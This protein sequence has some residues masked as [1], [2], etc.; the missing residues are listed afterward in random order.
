M[1]KEDKAAEKKKKE[2][3]KAAKAAEK[4]AAKNKTVREAKKQ[5]DKALMNIAG[6]LPH[7]QGKTFLT[8]NF[9]ID[10]LEEQKSAINLALRGEY[11]KLKEMKI[12][13]GA[14]KD[15]RKVRKMAPEDAKALMAT[16]ALYS[17][18][19]GMALSPDQK[20]MIEDINEKREAARVALADAHG[21]DTGKEVGS[22]TTPAPSLIGH[23]SFKEKTDAKEPGTDGS[24]DGEEVDQE[25][26]PAYL[27]KAEIPAKN[28]TL[29]TA[30]SGTIGGVASAA[31]H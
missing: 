2:S 23:N 26:T 12:E 9:A 31:K 30:E 14:L 17:D 10:K 8:V 25:P 11:A 15:V 27:K 1:T 24:G 28:I 6:N 4:K 16:R 20:K 22:Q 5:S 21:G 19:F 7:G 18:M 3:I 29:P 13:I